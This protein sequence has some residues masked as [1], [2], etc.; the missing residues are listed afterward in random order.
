MTTTNPAA[1]YP[2]ALFNK[3]KVTSCNAGIK[4]D[5]CSKAYW[6]DE[7]YQNC[8]ECKTAYEPI[9]SFGRGSCLTI[10]ESRL[11]ANCYLY[12][13]SDK[14]IQCTKEYLLEDGNCDK[15]APTD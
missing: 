14:C 7:D 15:K 1:I 9:E 4:V 6:I 11:V 3:F 2:P 10:R 13:K 12:I 5:G 8:Y